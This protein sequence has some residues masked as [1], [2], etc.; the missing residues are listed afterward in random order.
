MTSDHVKRDQVHADMWQIKENPSVR[1][2][3]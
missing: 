2:F 1:Y 3:L